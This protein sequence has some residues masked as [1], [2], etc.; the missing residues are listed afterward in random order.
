MGALLADTVN[1]GSSL[2]FLDGLTPSSAADWWRARTPAVERGELTVWAAVDAHAGRC[3]GT[4]SL[5]R[6]DKATGRHR[7]EVIK[8]M[9]HS[10]AR[11]K[12]LARA[13]LATVERAAAEAGVSLLVLDTET[14]SP[15]ETLYRA[16]GWTEAGVIPDYAADPAGTLRPT[17][18]FYKHPAQPIVAARQV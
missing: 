16:E 17:T 15:A 11:G 4:V 13:L 18:V 7:A 8:L 3:V 6:S 12:G 9:V 2:G 5:A 14:G 10:A 1:E